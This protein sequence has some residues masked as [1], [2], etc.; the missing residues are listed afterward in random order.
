MVTSTQIRANKP[1]ILPFNNLTSTVD[2][3]EPVFPELLVLAALRGTLRASHL[4]SLS[5]DL[6]MV[7][8][9]PVSVLVPKLPHS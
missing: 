9:L 2:I 8:M 3:P 4:L 1:Q 7:K 6:A 5:W